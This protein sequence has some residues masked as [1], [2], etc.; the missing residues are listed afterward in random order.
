MVTLRRHFLP[1]PADADEPPFSA[2]SLARAAW[3]AE[4]FYERE[5][6]AVTRGIAAAFSGKPSP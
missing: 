4:Y 6:N 3:L 2:L 5:T 1:S